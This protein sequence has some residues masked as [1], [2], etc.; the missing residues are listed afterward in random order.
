MKL[1]I[2]KLQTRIP[3]SN[4]DNIGIIQSKFVEFVKTYPTRITN[5]NFPKR[6]D[7]SPVFEGKELQSF[8]T[9]INEEQNEEF[10]EV[11]VQVRTIIN[12]IPSLIFKS[13]FKKMFDYYDLAQY[14]RSFEKLEALHNLVNTN[15]DFMVSRGDFI[16]TNDGLKC[17]EFNLGTNLGGWE[18]NI[19]QNLYL[20]N[21][22]ITTFIKENQLVILPQDTLAQEFTHIIESTI[23]NVKNI[24][25]EVNTVFFYNPGIE[26]SQYYIDLYSQCI[27]KF[28]SLKGALFF[29][30][31]KELSVK[32]NKVYLVNIRIAAVVDMGDLCKVEVFKCFKLNT[33]MVYNT[34][35]SHILGD[36]LNM[37]LLHDE[38]FN[39]RFSHRDLEL[40]RKYIPYAL[41]IEPVNFE[42]LED[43][44]QNKDEW[45][46]KPG[47]GAAG[48]GVFVG[49]EMSQDKWKNLIESAKKNRNSIVQ[50]FC[51][52][53][54]FDYMDK[55]NNITLH[56]L[57]FGFFVFGNTY[58]DGLIRLTPI[59]KSLVIN[60]SLGA[61][62]GF[63]LKVGSTS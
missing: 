1:R 53:L 55:E 18:N 21:I 8:P 30:S 13:D 54:A 63:F 37:A 4:T 47:Q 9:F 42:K 46:L 31:S 2:S 41:R 43:V 35:V 61:R 57:V 29:S 40:I 16:L 14:G 19:I 33:V 22:L 3:D 62:L 38:N 49:K 26:K 48:K 27:K 56:H 39:H 7:I 28:K 44:I 24:D 12:K 17:I 52:P 10:K 50:K 59:D 20:K 6:E 15:P 32:E 11:S 45:V 25:N 23:Q 60:V 58:A 5:E 36:K 34:P 51:A